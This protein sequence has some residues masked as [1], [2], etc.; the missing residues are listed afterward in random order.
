MKITKNTLSF[1]CE[2]EYMIGDSCHNPQSYDG[3]TGEEGRSFRY[4]ITIPTKDG[5]E[6]KTTTKLNSPHGLHT[7]SPKD[8]SEIKYKLGANH[9]YIGEALKNILE[10]IEKRYCIDFNEL[11]DAYQKPQVKT[12]N[13]NRSKGK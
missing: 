7:I 11:E 8:L 9:L 1:I 4:P 2:L 12:R 10:F 5:E 6:T 3:Y 13:A